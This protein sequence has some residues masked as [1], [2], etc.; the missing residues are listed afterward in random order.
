MSVSFRKII[1]VLFSLA[2]VG[3]LFFLGFLFLIKP[4][5]TVQTATLVRT[6][7]SRIVATVNEVEIS[8][9]IWQREAAMDTA[10]SLLAEQPQPSAEKVLDRLINAQLVLTAAHTQR[11]DLK[12]DTAQAEQ[13]LTALLKNWGKNEGDLVQSL[14]SSGISRPDLLAGIQTYLL[15]EAYLSQLDASTDSALWLQNQRKI[16]RVSIFTDL[17]ASTG[18]QPAAAVAELTT[19]TPTVVQTAP[20]PDA[21]LQSADVGT[22]EGQTA[23]D[24]ELVDLAGQPVRL[25]SFRGHPVVIN[26]WATWCPVCQK[27]FP[28]VRSAY[29]RFSPQGV[30]LLGVDLRE[31]VE[32]VSQVAQAQGLTYPILLDSD[33][34]VTSQYSVYGIP[35]TVVV[36]AQG[37]VTSRLTGPLTEEKFSEMV[38]PLLSQTG[39]G[40]EAAPA[41]LAVSLPSATP[42]T[43]LSGG[44]DFTLPDQDGKFL[45]LKEYMTDDKE[46]VILVFYR[47]QT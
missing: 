4:G 30:V 1:L 35:T 9:Q 5:Q 29:E 19:T 11:P 16:A 42:S 15:I 21:V 36:D 47:G 46:A 10:M 3:S 44:K 26:F 43:L 18:E 8:E 38:S 27:E 6:D 23:P 13:R 32:L 22:A 31:P 12:F 25:S 39:S 2:I 20:T 45:H 37:I 28:A 34:V 40:V 14:Q 17:A 41:A 24:F 33:G 7:S